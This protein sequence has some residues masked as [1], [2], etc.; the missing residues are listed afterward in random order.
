MPFA[1]ILAIFYFVILLPMRRRQKKVHEFLDTLKVGDKVVT[2]GGLYGGVTKLGDKA[3]QLQIAD[4]V[5]VE[6][7]RSA[8]VGYQGQAPVVPEG[9]AA[10]EPGRTRRPG[11]SW[12]VTQHGQEPALEAPRDRGVVALGVWMIYPLVQ[13]VRLGLDLKGGVHLVLRVQTDEALRV[14]SEAPMERLRRSWPRPAPPVS[15]PRPRAR[16]VRNPGRRRSATRCVRQLATEIE[17]RT[18]V[19]RARAAPIGSS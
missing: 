5:R 12:P 19:S 14:E 15:Q 13:K 10:I 18:T 7:A 2:T 4:R 16:S 8:V 6:V 3:L 9:T 11:A 1:L 17:T